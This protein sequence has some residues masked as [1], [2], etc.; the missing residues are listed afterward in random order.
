MNPLVSSVIPL[1]EA[2]GMS[3]YTHTYTHTYTQ[4]NY[5]N[6]RCVHVRR[7]LITVD[8][9]YYGVTGGEE[10]ALHGSN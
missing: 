1:R 3:G 8:H 7:G 4:D 9:R 6:P 10:D 2:A 5:S